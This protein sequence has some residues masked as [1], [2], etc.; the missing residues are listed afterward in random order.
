MNIKYKNQDVKILVVDNLQARLNESILPKKKYFLVTDDNVHLLY[1][2]IITKYENIQTYILPP[3][4][5]SKSID[6]VNAIIKELLEHNYTKDDYLIAFGGGMIGDLTGFVAGIYKRGIKYINIPTTLISQVDSSIGGKVAVNFEGYK[7]QVGLI[8]HPELILICPS[9]LKTLP[10]AEY[11]SGMG[12]VVK[13]AALFSEEL[14]H[15]LETNNFQLAT[16]IKECINLKVKLTLA[17]EFDLNERQLLNFGH[18]IG[19]A[20]EAKYQISHGI[21]I[22]YGM[23]L[24][25]KNERIKN[26]LIKLGFD[27]SKIFSELGPYIMQDKKIKNKLI[28][29]IKLISIGEAILEEGEID[30]YIF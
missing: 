24:E 14:F 8:Y 18:T 15:E 3:G 17:D 30:E 5:A 7:N 11:L 10:K 21:A 27:F 20:I 23:W 26:L 19:H 28:T 16:V 22:G 13:Y 1:A 2:S 9:V 25:S 6:N 12:E 4:E 29:K